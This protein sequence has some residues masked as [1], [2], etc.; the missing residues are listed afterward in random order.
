MHHFTRPL[1]FVYYLLSSFLSL[2]RCYQVSISDPS[3]KC[4][5]PHLDPTYRVHT[6]V[7]CSGGKFT[8][9]SFLNITLKDSTEAGLVTTCQVQEKY[10]HTYQGL[11]PGCNV[12]LPSPSPSPTPTPLPTPSPTP[13]PTPTPTPPLLPDAELQTLKDLYDSTN[14]AAWTNNA[15]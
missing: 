4:S 7:Y 1:I 2:P 11:G 3:R 15:K 10:L 5:Y 6:G 12:Y 13:T 8:G 14:G 9:D